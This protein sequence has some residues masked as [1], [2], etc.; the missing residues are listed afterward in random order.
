MLRE[1]NSMRKLCKSSLAVI[2]IN[3]LLGLLVIPEQSYAQWPP[4]D[5]ELIPSYADGKI[6]YN[7]EFRDRVDWTMTNVTIKIPI[8]AGT[9]FIEANA[10]P[11]IDTSFD[12]SEV[13][14][15]ASVL[16]RRIRTGDAFFVV[17]VT[18][19][20]LT[21]VNSHAWIAWEGN[22]PGDY[23]TEDEGINI[24]RQ[25]LNWEKPADS[26]LQLEVSATV[27]DE[28]ITYYI[29]PRNIR[30]RMWDLKINVPVPQGTTFVSADA[31]PPFVSQF[32]GQEV[33]FSI[34]ELVPGVEVDP[35]SFTVSADGVT[36][37]EVTTH[38]WA[39][40]KNVGRNVGRSVVVQ[41]ETLTNDI[42]VQPHVPQQIVIDDVGDVPFSNYDMSRIA[43]QEVMLPDGELA[44]KINF[45]T[46]GSLDLTN[47]PLRYTLYIDNDCSRD[48][49]ERQGRLGV[50]YNVTYQENKRA[51]L[52]R[53]NAEEKRW[54]RVKHIKATAPVGENRVVVWAPYALLDNGQAFCWTVEARNT[55]SGR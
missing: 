2:V 29:Y 18:D 28:S 47:D 52:E 40:W 27:T 43:L 45:Y 39:T 49:G 36:D 46:A 51:K 1:S 21:V 20:T 6:T 10:I 53:W 13:T 33:S 32:D 34:V 50:E 26:H 16:N 9:R 25:P 24:T 19:P 37:S 42:V 23:L 41:E 22:Q 44:L 14:F 35:L 8:P 4:F 48:S 31:P 12:G 54:D 17:E 5:F 11:T 55:T 3:L 7:L 38:A 30:R 15:Y